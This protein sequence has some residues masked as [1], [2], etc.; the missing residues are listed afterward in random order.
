MTSYG[1]KTG[2]LSDDFKLFH[3]KDKSNI[4]FDYHYHDFNKLI[5]F[6]SGNVVYNIEGKAYE[7]QPWDILLVPS[8]QVHKP[9]IEPITEYERIVFWI[10][11]SFLEQHSSENGKLLSCFSIA[12]NDMMHVIRPQLTTLDSL[13]TLLLLLEKEIKGRDFASTIMAN[14]LFVQMI[15]SINR[16]F[17][18]KDA[19]IKKIEVQYDESILKILQYINSNIEKELTIEFLSAKF[20]INKFY[21]MHKFKACT[22]Y[23]LHNYINNK[24]L[25][26]ANE[27]IKNGISMSEAAQ[28]CGFNDYSS[29][30]RAFK[31][32]F[33]LSPKNYLKQ[34]NSL[35]KQIVIE[36]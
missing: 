36:G 16:L 8:G 24:R 31:R 4:Q 27:L 32:Q 33:G 10:N 34:I 7:L 18:K 30:V 14:S 19:Q 25:I 26:K 5:I 1:I 21:L 22:G 20:F 29:F 6:I 13:K 9:L 28:Q 17:I 23:T 3:L 11:N 2:K 12:Q 15:I 35:Y